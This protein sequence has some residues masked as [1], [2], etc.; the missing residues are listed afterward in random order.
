MRDFH[1]ANRS[2][3]LQVLVNKARA[4]GDEIRSMSKH[5]TKDG[6][7]L[8]ISG[9][10]SEKG[11]FLMGSSEDEKSPPTQKGQSSHEKNLDVAMLVDE[12]FA[13]KNG[14]GG[15]FSTRK[16]PRVI[17]NPRRGN[18]PGWEVKE[19]PTVAPRRMIIN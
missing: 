5:R 16:A 18:G 8:L 11:L 3:S 4:V 17:P 10:A 19:T 12:V 9:E 2:A 13:M 15:G 1:Q 6:K 7:A 14:G